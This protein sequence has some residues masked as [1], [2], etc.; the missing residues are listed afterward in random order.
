MED[1]APVDHRVRPCAANVV[2]YALE[3]G[4][5]IVPAAAAVD[6]RPAGKV[7]AEVGIPKE[8]N[9]SLSHRADESIAARGAAGSGRGTAE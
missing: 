8:D 3:V 7:E 6:A 9:T 1:V 2:E 5:E 4:G